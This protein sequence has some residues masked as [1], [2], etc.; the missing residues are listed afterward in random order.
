MKGTNLRLGQSPSLGRRVFDGPES[1]SVGP[2]QREEA[3]QPN[4]RYAHVQLGAP[5]K[6]EKVLLL[7]G[8]NTPG[9]LPEL[10][11]IWGAIC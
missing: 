7:T 4:N 1:N 8:A 6:I 9:G 10:L 11:M 3:L 5:I 2:F